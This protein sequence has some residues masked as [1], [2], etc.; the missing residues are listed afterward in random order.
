MNSDV[1]AADVTLFDEDG[2]ELGNHT[3]ENGTDEKITFEGLTNNTLYD[4]VVDNVVIKN[5]QYDELYTSRTSDLTLKNKPTLG[6]ISVKTNNDVKTFTLSM[7]SVTDEDNAIVKYTYQIFEAEDITEET[8]A[9]AEPIYSFSR[10]ELEEEILK[11]DEAKNLYGNK[12]Y[13]FKIVAQYYDNYRYNE[14]ETRYSDYFQVVGKPTITFEAS[15]IDINRIAGTVLIEDTD[16]TI[17]FDGRECSDAPN[18]FVIRY[19]GGTTATRNT[20]ENVVIDPEN[21]SLSF[22]LNGLQENTL[23]TFEVYADI[24]L[25]NGEGL[26]T[27]QYI[28][29]FNVSTTG[30]N[31]LMMQ[32]WEIR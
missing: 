14:I 13:R 12:D 26:Q 32:N 1:V 23:Y 3:V 16:C 27:S 7:D 8:I 4:I 5:V 9:T 31:A 25:K 10:T 18:N 6:E 15:E 11:L 2:N 22:D 19:Y 30:I 28:G 20:V 24:D 17:P 29:G 21:L